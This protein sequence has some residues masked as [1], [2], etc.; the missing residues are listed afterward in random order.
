M[1][2]GKL[3]L[4]LLERMSCGGVVLDASGNVLQANRAAERVFEQLRLCEREANRCRT[5]K[6]LLTNP[7][8]FTSDG[9]TWGCVQQEGGRKLLVHAMRLETRAPDGSDS[10]IILIDLG[11]TPIINHAVLQDAFELTAAEASLAADIAA[12][13]PLAELA[14]AKRVSIATAR[15]QLASIFGKTRTRRQAELVAL[16]TRMSI[17][18]SAPGEHTGPSRRSVQGVTGAISV[19]AGTAA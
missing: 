1:P 13:K 2:F 10:L 9:N 18:P 7:L 14:N 4:D 5:V 8:R 12:G 19:V 3:L 16:L 15:T 17:L 6:K 11:V